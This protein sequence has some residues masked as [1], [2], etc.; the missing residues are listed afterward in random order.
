VQHPKGETARKVCQHLFAI[1]EKNASTEEKSYLGTV[2][3][4]ITEGN[5]SDMI[6][7][8]VRKKASKTDLT[9]AIFSVYSSLADC[10]ENNRVYI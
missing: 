2:K 5:L 9:E 3:R 1:A 6:L 7:K 8:Q 10:L 4:R